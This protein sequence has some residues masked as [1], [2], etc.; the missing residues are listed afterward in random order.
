MTADQFDLYDGY[1]GRLDAEAQSAVRRETYDE[2][3]GQSSWITLAEARDWFGLLELGPGRAVLEVAC[4][5]GG[6]TCHMALETGATCVGVDINPHGIEAA[7]KRAVEADLSSQV[8]FQRVDAGRP[9]PFPDASFDAIFCNDSIN[10]IPG[11]AD[12]LRDWHRV[13]RPGGRLLYTDPVVVTGPVTN[14][15]IRVRS[16]IGFFLFLPLGYNERLL[17]DAGFAV[18]EAR[19]VSDA[20]ASISQKWRD[21][22]ARRREALVRVE[23]EEDFDN[24]QR[25]LAAVH[26]LTAERRLS[27]Y[28]FLASKP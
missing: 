11:R 27:R 22:R 2:D 14:E 5:S 28:M 21:A 16:S 23:G 4:G 26:T 3:V 8:S 10:H 20:A 9:L 19:D 12:V 15:E 1:Y 25:F 18:L 24:L 17:K 6:M 7:Q 13:L